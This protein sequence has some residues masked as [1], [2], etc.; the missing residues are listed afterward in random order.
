M[1]TA[2]ETAPTKPRRA[3]APKSDSITWTRREEAFAFLLTEWDVNAAKDIIEAKPRR[4]ERIDVA[5]LEPFL[6]KRTETET[7]MTIRAG[8]V[9]DD[10]RV[11]NDESIDLSIPIIVAFTPGGNALAI[12]GWHRIAK[13]VA[14]G[15]EKLPAVCLTKAESKRVWL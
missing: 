11:A 7:G 5:C 15:V 2:T 8:I 1:T 13:A 14:L 10:D 6:S 12:D 3:R 9:V 4:I